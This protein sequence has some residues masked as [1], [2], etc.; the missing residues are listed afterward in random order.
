[1]DITPDLVR[2]SVG[3]EDVVDLIDDLKQAM[4]EAAKEP[5]PYLAVLNNS[6]L[7]W[8]GPAGWIS[9]PNSS[10][11]PD[12]FGPEVSNSQNSSRSCLPQSIWKRPCDL[13]SEITQLTTI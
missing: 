6:G 3:L 7:V 11:R 10:A 13:C 2:I 5:M 4:K 8:A 12:A 1:M 9:L